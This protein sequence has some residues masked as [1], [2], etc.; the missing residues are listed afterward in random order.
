MSKRLK[1]RVTRFKAEFQLYKYSVSAGD[2]AT[3]QAL[4]RLMRKRALLIPG[5]VFELGEFKKMS[6]GRERA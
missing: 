6:T 3:A 2:T 1:D 4:E 5:D